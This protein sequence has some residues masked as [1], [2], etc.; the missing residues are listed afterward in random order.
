[1]PR[2]KAKQSS[3]RSAGLLPTLKKPAEAIGLTCHTPG[4]FWDGCP[5]ADKKKLYSCNVRTFEAVH[6]FPGSRPPSSA[7]EVQ[8][9]G[10]HGTGSLEPGVA[11][12]EVFWTLETEELSPMLDKAREVMVYETTGRFFTERPSNGRL[13]QCYISK[14]MPAEL[15]MP[16]TWLTL[17]KS[18]YVQ[19]LRQATTII[20]IGVRSSPPRKKAKLEQ[21]SMFRASTS[22]L[23]AASS[24]PPP[25][26]NATTEAEFDTVSDEIARY[27][28][29]PDER[30]NRFRDEVGILNEFALMYDLKDTFPLHYIV[31]RQVSAHLP[32]FQPSP[33]P[34]PSPGQYLSHWAY[35]SQK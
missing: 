32:P 22:A 4:D 3:L 33:S 21:P 19:M 11:S 1:M 23:A 9:M 14:Q 27:K 2:C 24:T 31:F 7:F 35:L 6:K 25:T 28:V 13:V 30:A 17:A 26:A 10:E 34:S 16:A 20:G 8:E 18:L 12:G 5:A 29:M 15:W